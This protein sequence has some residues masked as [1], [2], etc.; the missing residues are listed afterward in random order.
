[1]SSETEENFLESFLQEFDLK[2]EDLNFYF[3]FD[4]KKFVRVGGIK[5]SPYSEHVDIPEE[6]K[7]DWGSLPDNFRIGFAF[8]CLLQKEI[9]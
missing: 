9:V 5:G 4:S 6:M 2:K 1:M 7:E 3:L 8:A